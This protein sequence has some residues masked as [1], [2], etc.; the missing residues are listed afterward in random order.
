MSLP[1]DPTPEP[2][3]DDP[4]LREGCRRAWGGER[5]PA[6]L[7]DRVAAALRDELQT[8]AIPAKWWRPASLRG[9]AAAAVLVLAVAGVAGYYAGVLGDGRRAGTPVAVLPASAIPTT[10]VGQ[11]TSVHQA[12][13]AGNHHVIAPAEDFRQIEERLSKHLRRPVIAC[14]PEHFDDGH[15]WI[16][17]GAAVCP[18]GGR[19]AGHL[20]FTR[21][22]ASVSVFSLPAEACPEFRADGQCETSS[23]ACDIAAFR[24]GNGVFCVVGSSKDGSLKCDEVRALRDKLRRDVA[25]ACGEP[26]SC[27]TGLHAGAAPRAEPKSAYFPFTSQP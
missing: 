20:V 13:S 7:R 26:G 10:L 11:L 14:S 25:A 4:A 19:P 15:N 8:A 23:T 3:F 17:G 12:C 16:F 1:H 5:A 2:R 9:L 22:Q 6:R 21:G 18:V 27:P 24:R